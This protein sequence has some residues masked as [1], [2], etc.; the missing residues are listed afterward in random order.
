MSVLQFIK[1]SIFV[2]ERA[3][4]QR[5]LSPVKETPKGVKELAVEKDR[6]RRNEQTEVH[7][8]HYLRFLGGK[9]VGSDIPW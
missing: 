1:N 9:K 6:C 4:L 5:N 8:T 7:T 3:T 2:N